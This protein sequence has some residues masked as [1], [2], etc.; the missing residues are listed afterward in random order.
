[1]VAIETSLGN[2][3]FARS[4]ES[5]RERERGKEE[6]NRGSHD[7]RRDCF[8]LKGIHERVYRYGQ[9]AYEEEELPSEMM[10][11]KGEDIIVIKVTLLR[12]RF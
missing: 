5:R 7:Q 12:A 2:S 9:E 4:Q 3:T 10:L 8:N 11:A 1:M 6:E